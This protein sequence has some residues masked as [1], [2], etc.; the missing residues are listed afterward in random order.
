M[1]I[2][3][4]YVLEVGPQDQAINQAQTKVLGAAQEYLN[5]LAGHG[6]TI[7]DG[8]PE[9]VCAE[10][11]RSREDKRQGRTSAFFQ[12]DA[13]SVSTET[14]DRCLR[15]LNWS[16]QDLLQILEPLPLQALAWGYLG[17]SDWTIKTILQH[18]AGAERWYLT[19]LWPH[20]PEL[21]RSRTPQERLERVRAGSAI[22]NCCTLCRTIDCCAGARQR[23]LEP[24]QGSTQNAVPRALSFAQ[25][26]GDPERPGINNP[27]DC[28]V[29]TN[30]THQTRRMH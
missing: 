21:P 15:L 10:V 5:W 11:V 25:D 30:T 23:A 27:I 19:K 7:L 3:L 28:F 20:L 4:H 9:L 17:R 12:A 26:R 2:Q 24:A 16:R 13:E 22:S 18:I 8:K 6:E 29:C 1:S 14:L